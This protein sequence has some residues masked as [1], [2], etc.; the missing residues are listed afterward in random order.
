[1]ASQHSLNAEHYLRGI[2][3]LPTVDKK[4]EGIAKALNEIIQAVKKL[5]LEYPG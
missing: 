4:L 5:E 3:V 1:M 2:A